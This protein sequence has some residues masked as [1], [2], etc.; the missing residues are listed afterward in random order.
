LDEF[1]KICIN[2]LYNVGNFYFIME[3]KEIKPGTK[4]KIKTRKED[5]SCRVLESPRSDIVL[6]KLNSGYNIGIRE[7]DILDLEVVK[8]KKEKE[9]KKIDLK[10][11]KGLK[12]IALV[13]TGGTISSR[14]DYKTGGVKW[15][16]DPEELLKFYPEI[17]EIANISKIEVPF[18][19]AS[20]DMD[21]KDWEVIAKSVEGLLND[22]SIEGVIVTHGTDFLH[23]TAA[24]LSFSLRN[25][26]KPV[27]LTYSQRSSDRASSDARLNLQCAARVAV[28]D[29]AEVVLVGHGTINDDFCF[30]IRG[31]KVR[32][33]HTSRRDTFRAIN[34]KPIAK[35]FS[36]KLEILRD[37]NVRDNKKKVELRNKF[38][39]KVV[40]LK[41]YPGLDPGIFDYLLERGIKGVVI[42]ASG[43][44]HVATSDARKNIISKIKKLVNSGVVVGV[45]PQTLYG[46]LNPWVYS[47]GREFLET[48]AIFLRDILPETAF[49]KMSWILGDKELRKNVKENLGNN[50]EK[51]FN[52]F[53]SEDEFLN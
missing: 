30:A 24:A 21:S 27:V 14:L 3:V 49:V 53:I 19:K 8:D 5:I 9:E 45:T 32:K 36:D 50:F 4:V 46:K 33:M 35:V 41:F 37:Y 39:D 18:M 6:V 52:E 23:Y 48:G 44:G 51:E 31:T 16:T 1:I 20:E 17:L 10:I 43:L 42:E 12:N 25:L 15:L 40:L 28:S 22:S 7:E 29:I 38:S 34:D 26:N 11:R 2:K 47:N 13:V